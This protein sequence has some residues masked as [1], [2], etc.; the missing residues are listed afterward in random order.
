MAGRLD[1]VRAMCGTRGGVEELPSSH[2]QSVDAARRVNTSEGRHHGVLEN[3]TSN[4]DRRSR[5]EFLAAGSPGALEN[6]NHPCIVARKHEDETDTGK[7]LKRLISWSTEGCTWD[8][9]VKYAK[10]TAEA[11]DKATAARPISPASRFVEKGVPEAVDAL[12]A[13]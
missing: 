6:V 3:R 10:N 5:N 7:Y 9:D 4:N 11:Y 8:S 1:M 12:P 13:A 2:H